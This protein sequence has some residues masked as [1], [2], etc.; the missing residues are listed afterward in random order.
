[1]NPLPDQPTVSTEVTGLV[2]DLDLDLDLDPEPT[3]LPSADS[4]SQK[5]FFVYLLCTLDE[6]YTYI[7]ATVNVNHRLRQHNGEI[8]G[9]AKYTTSKGLHQWKRLL[10]VS[11]F[12]SW[13]DALRFEWRWKQLG[14]RRRAN[15]TSAK[16]GTERRIHDLTV[17]LS[18]PK[19]TTAATPYAE[20]P[21]PPEVHYA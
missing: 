3:E 2:K 18:F 20:W 15:Q 21:S 13:K 9:G 6:K 4:C 1:M 11:G 10:Y 8:K 5:S 19:A 17:L 7:G 14:R 12:P 16:S